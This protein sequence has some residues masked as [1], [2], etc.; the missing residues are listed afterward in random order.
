MKKLL[1]TL[2][3]LFV[4]AI[5]SLSAQTRIYPPTLL[6]PENEDDGQMPD[7]VLNWAAVGGSGGI[8]EYEVQIDTSALFTDPTTFPKTDLSAYQM[9]LLHFG[10]QYYWR[11]RAWEG[12]EVSEWSEP[13]TFF[14]FEMVDLS[15]PN[16]NAEEQNPNVRLIVK[17]R[18]GTTLITGIEHIYFEADTSMDF[19]SPLLYHGMSTGFDINASFLHFGQTYHW[20]AKAMHAEDE[21]DWSDLRTFTIIPTVELDK[22]D[23]NSTDLGLENVLLWDA[24]SGVID[25]TVQ[26]ANNEAFTG[27]ILS[28][29]VEETQYTTDGFLHFGNEYFWRVRAN[30]AKD[31]SEWSETW[32]FTTTSTVHLAS[33]ANNAVDVSINPLMEWDAISG[34]DS[35]HLQY[36]NS[37]N[38]TDP[39]CNE[40][41]APEENFYQVIFI[42]DYETEYFWRCRT[43]KGIDTTEWSEVWSFTTRARD[44]GID[45]AAFDA[46]NISVYPNPSSGLLHLNIAGDDNAEVSIHIMDL[47]GQMHYES[48]V[49]FGQNNTNH[50]LDLGNLAN[51]LY[52]MKLKRGNK[53]YS[54]KITIHR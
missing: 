26:M 14:T 13:F 33:P 16:N 30:H 45:E 34:V 4:I 21:S 41:I 48:N 5:F 9:S 35:Y 36:N 32:S 15:K 37:N 3:F 51:G 28:M 44:F 54:Q 7:V 20:R 39:C 40:F 52:I 23:D 50:K 27:S 19:N 42:F 8:V 6:E 53:T 31:T 12:A 2:L 18:I 22:P 24:I 11:V 1:S 10:Q 25:Y 43:M 49:M 29:I 46:G 17:D 38:F 47:L